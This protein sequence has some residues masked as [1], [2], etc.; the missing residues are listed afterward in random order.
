MPHPSIRPVSDREHVCMLVHGDVGTG[1]TSLIG[2]G[3]KEYKTLILRPPV[4]HLQPIR[5]SGCSEWVMQNW[6]DCF[7]A[8]EYC[9]HEGMEWDWVWLDSI[10]LWQDVGLDDIWQAAIDRK[11]SRRDYGPDKGEYGINMGRIGEF[12]RHMVGP[13]L[14]NFGITAHSEDLPD[15]MSYDG[16]VKRLPW[17]Q[18]KG[19]ISKVSGYMNLVGYLDVRTREIRGEVRHQRV[20]H[21]QKTELY[22]AKDQ[23]DAFPNGQ[24][25]NPTMPKIMEAINEARERKQA[26]ERRERRKTT[27]RPIAKRAT[28]TRRKVKGA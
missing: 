17:I 20:L 24:M 2:S 12:V 23:F 21:T 26:D 10:S 3:G 6:T 15:P 11:P 16:D 14:F 22:Y 18:G 28:T 1:K 4:D 25:I 19:M 8:L 5:H 9:R 27:T 13:D 7:E